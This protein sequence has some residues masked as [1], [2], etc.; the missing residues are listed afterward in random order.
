MP[1]IHDN[2]FS[3]SN[4]RELSFL[5]LSKQLAFSKNEKKFN[6]CS[7]GQRPN[8]SLKA[9]VHILKPVRYFIIAY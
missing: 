6:Q 7:I 8:S 3:F 2:Y 5:F 9:R 4:A 1:S